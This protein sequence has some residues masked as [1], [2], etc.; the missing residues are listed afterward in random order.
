M[1]KFNFVDYSSARKI[2]L[3]QISHYANDYDNNLL[4][5]FSYFTT[6]PF[7]L[8]P[9]TIV[10]KYMDVYKAHMFSVL[11][12]DVLVNNAAIGYQQPAGVSWCDHVTSTINTNF[13][14]TLNL[15]RALLPLMRPHGRIVMVSSMDGTLDILHNDLQNKFSSDSLTETQLVAMMDEFIIDAIADNHVSKGWSY[16]PYAVSKVGLNALTRVLARDISSSNQSNVIINT[17][18]PGWVRTDM[19]GPMAPLDVKQGAETPVYL[20]MLPPGSP[21]GFFWERKR[22]VQF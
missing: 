22:K 19:G 9:F 11:G 20:A 2:S 16:S 14:S 10:M 8:E 5:I 21:S 7:H 4:Q 3:K 17:C 12:V 13:T 1:E 18:C 15:T 6:K